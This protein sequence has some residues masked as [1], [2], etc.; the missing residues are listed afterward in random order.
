MRCDGELVT[1][2]RSPD[3]AVVPII[4]PGSSTFYRPIRGTTRRIHG[5]LASGARETYDDP[6]RI[7]ILV[8]PEYARSPTYGASPAVTGRRPLPKSGGHA[9]CS[10]EAGRSRCAARCARV[11]LRG[12]EGAPSMDSRGS[13]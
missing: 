5:R 10:G 3:R 9:A 2:A 8:G 12:N 1:A 11:E 7:R 13:M 4:P 6:R